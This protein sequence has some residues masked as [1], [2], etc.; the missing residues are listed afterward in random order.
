MDLY[1]KLEEG[2]GMGM[3]WSVQEPPLF[4]SSFSHILCTAARQRS[5]FRRDNKETS[6][7]CV[8]GFLGSSKGILRTAASGSLLC[9]TVLRTGVGLQ[10][11][12]LSLSCPQ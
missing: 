9:P 3:G 5:S 4:M 7:R 8:L 2:M 12:P 1:Q 6:F 11:C 10:G